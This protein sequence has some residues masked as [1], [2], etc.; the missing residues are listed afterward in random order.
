MFEISH[1]G[2]IYTIQIGKYYKSG[3]FG[4][5]ESWFT[6]TSLVKMKPCKIIKSIRHNMSKAS[7]N[8]L[9]RDDGI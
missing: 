4:F 6:S 1:D 3:L 5:F 7:I 9:A 8:V 2:N